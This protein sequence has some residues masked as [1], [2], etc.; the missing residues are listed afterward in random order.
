[1]VLVVGNK[2]RSAV[3]ELHAPEVWT[4][5]QARD[6][7]AAIRRGFHATDIAAAPAFNVLKIDVAQLSLGIPDA[8]AGSIVED[9]IA[10][11]EAELKRLRGI[12]RGYGP[13]AFSPRAE[14]M[15]APYKRAGENQ[16]SYMLRWLNI[17]GDQDMVI[18]R[19]GDSLVARDASGAYVIGEG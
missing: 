10:R 14:P 5:R 17:L 2:Y 12:I 8:V 6:I 13:G 4:S 18:V 15:V 9:G 16:E 7:C 3:H 1:M 19:A 11:A